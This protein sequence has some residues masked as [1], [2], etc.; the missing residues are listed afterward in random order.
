MRQRVKSPHRAHTIQVVREGLFIYQNLASVVALGAAT[1]PLSGGV[2][3]AHG[4]GLVRL[5][6][7]FFLFS[8]FSLSYP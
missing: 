4:E 2:A 8:L 1:R 3:C 5:Q 7:S 6:W